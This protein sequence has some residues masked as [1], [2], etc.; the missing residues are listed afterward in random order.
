MSWKLYAAYSIFNILQEIALE[1]GTILGTF[2]W[3]IVRKLRT[4]NL[5]QNHLV[6][7]VN[8]SVITFLLVQVCIHDRSLMLL[9]IIL[10]LLWHVFFNRRQMRRE[11]YKHCG[12]SNV[13]KYCRGEDDN[14]SNQRCFL[15]WNVLTRACSF[16]KPIGE[17]SL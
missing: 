11:V 10:V 17:R 15:A 5:C 9:L 12:Q 1:V 8:K 3:K 4:S 16:H 2:Q 6:L 14:R 7:I 13:Q